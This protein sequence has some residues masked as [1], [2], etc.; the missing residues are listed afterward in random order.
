MTTGRPDS[1]EDQLMCEHRWV[2]CTPDRDDPHCATCGLG[3]A[4]YV[5]GTV[6][7]ALSRMG[8]WD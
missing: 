2:H 8:A 4:D 3:Y 5:E 1:A 7:A 6:R